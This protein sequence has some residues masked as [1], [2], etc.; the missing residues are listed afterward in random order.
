MRQ[1]LCRTARQRCLHRC[2]SHIHPPVLC[3]CRR[4]SM[5][6]RD[7]G[8]A[9]GALHKSRVPHTP[10]LPT[11]APLTKP[12][13]PVPTH[14]IPPHPALYS[15]PPHLAWHHTPSIRSVSH[16]PSP[17]CCSP[18][19]PIPIHHTWHTQPYSLQTPHA[20][21]CTSPCS[22]STPAMHPA[23]CTPS[24]G[25]SDTPGTHRHGHPPC[26]CSPWVQHCAEGD[27]SP[28]CSQPQGVC[29]TSGG[30]PAQHACAIPV[31]PAL[32]TAEE[33][34]QLLQHLLHLPLR[35]GHHRVCHGGPAVLPHRPAA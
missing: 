11:P 34:Q 30:P 2:H 3:Y 15:V 25:H 19:T 17:T 8:T 23:R 22:P 27:P 35:D 5:E 33:T 1:V 14:H 10:A 12:C 6:V 4:R 16:M 32:P 13:T 7:V 26:T 28:R 20:V 21:P 9:W 31:S 24:S 29:G 18:Y